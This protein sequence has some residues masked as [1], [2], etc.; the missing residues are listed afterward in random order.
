MVRRAAGVGLSRRSAG[1]RRRGSADRRPYRGGAGRGASQRGWT[2]QGG[3]RHQGGLGA[4]PGGSRHRDPARPGAYRSRCARR[5]CRGRRCAGGAGPSGCF[6]S[7][8]RAGPRQPLVGPGR[9]AYR[10]AGAKRS[11][12]SGDVRRRSE[13]GARRTAPRGA[14][15]GGGGP[16]CAGVR[17][18]WPG[19]RRG[20]RGVG[21]GGLAPAPEGDPARRLGARSRRARR[22]DFGR[23]VQ[24]VHV[25]SGQAPARR[26]RVDFGRRAREV[27]VGSGRCPAGRVRSGPG[28][29]QRCSDPRRG[30]RVPR[31]RHG[32]SA[33]RDQPCRAEP[34]PPRGSARAESAWADHRGRAWPA[35]PSGSPRH[36]CRGR[37]PRQCPAWRVC[38]S[39]RVWRV[40]R[41]WPVPVR[42]WRGGRCCRPRRRRQGS[43][44]LPAPRRHGGGRSGTGRHRGRGRG[45]GVGTGRWVS[46]PV[47]P[48]RVAP[49]GDSAVTRSAALPGR[50]R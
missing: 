30:A 47:S 18:G 42:R 23:P 5:A 49:A 24:R 35:V 32:R 29:S 14:P 17:E 10:E 12:R 2:L 28:P 11:G 37:G 45:P 50:T 8:C 16:R 39:V 33:W 9:D 36:A 34:R 6:R 4:V 27:H 1:A 20:P 40:C 43:G 3:D 22:V 7:A 38:P 21:A 41:W 46:R 44:G 19:W 48:E 26:V 15:W 13:A 31:S 25:G